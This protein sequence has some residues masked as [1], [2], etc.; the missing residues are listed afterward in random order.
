[1]VTLFKT[2]TCPKCKVLAM[3]MNM[4]NIEF[5]EVTDLNVLA[6]YGI[7]E[8]PQLLVDDMPLMDMSAA[9]KWINSQEIRN[10]G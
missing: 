6:Q 8:V 9:N 1:M 10:N 5:K 7:T 3:K 2:E 4:K